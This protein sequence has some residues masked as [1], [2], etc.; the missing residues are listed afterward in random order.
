ML[1]LEEAL[2]AIRADKIL[3][4]A[5]GRG[6][7]IL[8]LQEQLG[9][10]G[11]AI[12]IDLKPS[13]SWQDP[14]FNPSGINFQVMDGAKM[15]FDAAS[16][17]LVAISNSLHH[18]PQSESVLGEMLRVLKP[19]GMFIFHEM[20]TDCQS[21]TQLTHT[22]L[23]QWWGKIDTASGVYHHSPYQRNE[24]V[25]LL[26]STGSCRWDFYDESDVSED[27]L[28]PQLI[29]ELIEIIERYQGR[30]QNTELIAEGEGLKQRVKSIGFH[31]APQLFSI[32]KKGG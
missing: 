1:K 10:F 6:D 32:G 12:G 11:Q 5:T 30:T 22:L 25:S 29:A 28:D 21:E 24:L 2:A 17:D 15:D 20:Y 9:A 23:H 16:F 18:L 13:D 31:S 8:L 19:S 27:P 3:D 7:F 14:Q 26:E 4:V